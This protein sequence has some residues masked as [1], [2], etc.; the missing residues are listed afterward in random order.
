[1]ETKLQE[2]IEYRHCKD[3]TIVAYRRVMHKLAFD[4]IHF[5]NHPHATKIQTWI[6][7]YYLK[8]KIIAKKPVRWHPKRK[9]MGYINN[10]FLADIKTVKNVINSKELWQKKQVLNVILTFLNP[11]KHELLTDLNK[12]YQL[13]NLTY[14][15]V[16]D[17]QTLQKKTNKQ[18]KNWVDWKRIL[19]FQ[20]KKQKLIIDNKFMSKDKLTLKEQKFLRDY[21]ILSLYTVIKPRRLDYANMIIMDSKHYNKLTVEEQ[22]K[23]NILVTHKHK[24]K[25]FSFGK[26]VQKNENSGNL[27][28]K[29]LLPLR[30]RKIIN[31]YLKHHDNESFLIGAHL[32][33]KQISNDA[34]SRTIV[35]ILATE[36]LSKNIGVSMIR[37]IY[38][39]WWNNKCL[40]SVKDKMK[41]AE[42]MGHSW[43]VGDKV[44]TKLD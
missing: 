5:K 43:V 7:K 27:V 18:E 16:L 15:K 1:M 4:C 20:K 44:Y 33:G 6:R 17:A 19:K 8:H 21:L 28:Y 14:R 40:R 35:R 29:L 41:C 30:M 3:N 11:R 9:Q 37:T 13:I 22:S 12:K 34:L 38:K 2:I 10:D 24:S 32:K 36:F 31:L 25:M 23:K 39:T 42:E 26:E